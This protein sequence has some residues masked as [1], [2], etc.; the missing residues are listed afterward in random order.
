MSRK[1]PQTAPFL[2]P[3]PRASLFAS[4]LSISLSLCRR[5][6]TSLWPSS[7]GSQALPQCSNM[8][9][10]RSRPGHYS[11]RSPAAARSLPGLWPQPLQT[12]GQRQYGHAVNGHSATAV[13]QWQNGRGAPRRTKRGVVRSGILPHASILYHELFLRARM[14]K[15]NSATAGPIA[16]GPRPFD[17]GAQTESASACPGPATPRELVEKCGTNLTAAAPARPPI[18]ACRQCEGA[19]QQCSHGLTSQECSNSTTPPPER[20]TR[21]KMSLRRR[22][23]FSYSCPEVPPGSA[24]CLPTWS[25]SPLT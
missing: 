4:S 7:I 1:R 21:L 22:F 8:S 6:R 19:F 25:L 13:V 16:T 12:V 18:A 15:A 17:R 5:L 2:A 3:L 9:T 20:E 23:P 14:T 11:L 24:T 10:N